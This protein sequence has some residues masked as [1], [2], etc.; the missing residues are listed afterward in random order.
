MNTLTLKNPIKINGKDVSELT[1][2][3]NEITAEAFIEAETRKFASAVKKGAT[4]AATIELDYSMQLEL[5]L[6]AILAVN[7]GYDYND[8]LRIKGTDLIGVVRIGRNF[9]MPS[10]VAASEESN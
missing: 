2:D 3:A 4:T 10:D 9:T 1:Y 8:L 5:G 6:A 7:D